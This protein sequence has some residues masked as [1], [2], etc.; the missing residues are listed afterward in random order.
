MSQ[1]TRDQRTRAGL[2]HA[3]N[4]VSVVTTSVDRGHSIDDAIDSTLGIYYKDAD[5][6]LLA[7]LNVQLRNATAALNKIVSIDGTIAAERANAIFN[8]TKLR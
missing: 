1:E 4:M 2:Q 5:P 6:E 7:G 8:G 3:F